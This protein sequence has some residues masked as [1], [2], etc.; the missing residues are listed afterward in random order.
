MKKTKRILQ[1]KNPTIYALANNV[2]H[3]F[4]GPFGLSQTI[5]SNCT[6][7]SISRQVIKYWILGN[8]YKWNNKHNRY[9]MSEFGLTNYL[10]SKN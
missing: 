10:K 5:E 7:K 2:N 8:W 6:L 3:K 1:K 4:G 9:R